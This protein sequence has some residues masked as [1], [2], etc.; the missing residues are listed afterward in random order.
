MG[1]IVMTTWDA[2]AIVGVGLGVLVIILGII[3]V[4]RAYQGA[5]RNDSRSM[6]LLAIGLLFITV[7]PSVATMTLSF[8]AQYLTSTTP[9]EY[10]IIAYR[11][12]EVL[13]IGILLYSIHTRR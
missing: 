8:V 13:G 3:L 9:I 4:W 2:V 5:R 12:S 6:L 11:A 1:G 7:F 10:T